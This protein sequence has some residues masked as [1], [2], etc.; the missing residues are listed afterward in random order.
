MLPIETPLIPQE[1][2]SLMQAV[3]FSGIPIPSN[4]ATEI[5][6]HWTLLLL[7]LLLLLVHLITPGFITSRFTTL[8]RQKQRDSIFTES[9]IVD[10][11][12]FI[13]SMLFA[14][15]STAL[16]IYLVTNS[17]DFT[18][19]EYMT[20]CAMLT[21]LTLIR[22]VAFT[23]LSAV[24][25]DRTQRRQALKNY[26]QIVFSTSVLLYVVDIIAVLDN[27]DGLSVLTT[28]LLIVC[29]L[30]FLASFIYKSFQIF[31]RH[32]RSA[33]YLFL[34]LCTLEF[35]PLAGMLFALKNQM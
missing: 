15:G 1:P 18:L 21:I 2:D 29:I 7:G 10:I 8:F 11:R 5:W 34:Y 35:A 25:T 20:C 9:S 3:R 16:C 4:A 30:W 23:A 14:V 27:T 31:Y 19:P 33:L 24:F 22:Y 13:A 28:I 32:T 12:T 26:Y 17:D 6:P